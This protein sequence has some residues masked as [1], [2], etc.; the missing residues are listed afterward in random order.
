M[1]S[2]AVGASQKMAETDSTYVEASLRHFAD[3]PVPGWFTG[4]SGRKQRIS[5]FD[6]LKTFVWPGESVIFG[7][8]PALWNRELTGKRPSSPSIFRAGP[9]TSLYLG[10]GESEISV[11]PRR[12]KFQKG[13]SEV[14]VNDTFRP[15]IPGQRL[16]VR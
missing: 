14:L 12:V 3:F 15:L 1:L 8:S 11:G 5:G 6:T 2:L 10:R 13:G 7:K 4:R 16:R 9:R